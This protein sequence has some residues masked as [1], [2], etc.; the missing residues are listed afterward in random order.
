MLHCATSFD[1]ACSVSRSPR[2]VAETL[3]HVFNC[4]SGALGKETYD[5]RSEQHSIR[6]GPSARAAQRQRDVPPPPLRKRGRSDYASAP[7]I[8][9]ATLTRLIETAK[10]HGVNPITFLLEAA[11]AA[12]RGQVLMPW[13]LA[14]P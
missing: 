3:A 8:F 5:G 2:C 6:I 1:G 10:L 11:R 9:V 12:E 4:F 7:S 13:K 14:K